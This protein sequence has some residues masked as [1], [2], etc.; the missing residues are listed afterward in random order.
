MPP[1]HFYLPPQHWPKTIPSNPDEPWLGFSVG[2]YAW[3]LQTYLRLRLVGFPC[4]LVAHLP[5]TGIVVVHRNLLSRLGRVLHP[6]PQRLLVCLKADLPPYP[7]AQLHVVQNGREAEAVRDYHFIPHWPQPGLIPRDGQR[8]DRFETVIFC[9]HRANLA[10][11]LQ[12]P[13]W[14][15]QLRDLGLTWQ[16]RLSDH[17]WD[18]D[19][20]IP[21]DWHDYSQVDGVVALRDREH[22]ARRVAFAHKPATKLYNAWL[23]GVP[24]ILG[25][26]SAY[27][28]ERQSDLDYIEVDSAE[29]AIQALQ[30]LQQTPGLRQAMIRNGLKRAQSRTPAAITEC[31]VDFFETV[32]IPAYER[33]RARPQWSQI[34]T[35]QQ[36]YCAL[37]WSRLWRTL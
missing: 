29:A 25:P 7:Y 10:A 26:E 33:W 30:R 34:I 6:H 35:A 11:E 1:I 18:G 36:H 5:E 3:T 2:L 15:E 13:A 21:R 31:W 4:K 23:A 17:R 27:R 24:A 12:Q 14:A 16:P 37:Q 22:P 28:A 32:A 8:A 20:S 19:Q 9:G